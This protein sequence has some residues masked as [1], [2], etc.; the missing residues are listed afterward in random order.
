[1]NFFLYVFYRF[2]SLYKYRNSSDS[3]THAFILIGALFL[4]HILTIVGFIETI[5][6]KDFINS[7]RTE[8]GFLDRFVLFPLLIA[9]IYIILFLY[10]KK[11]KVEIVSIIKI[12]RNESIEKRKRK[13]LI[14]IVY[15]LATILL[16]FLSTISPI[17]F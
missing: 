16:F 5:L 15:L 10:Y 11:H 1:M 12:F 7:L 3:G 2:K 14:V 6:Q 8:N 17:L 4:I 13:G 9:P